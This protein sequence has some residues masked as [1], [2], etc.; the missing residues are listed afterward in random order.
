MTILKSNSAFAARGFVLFSETNS[1]SASKSITVSAN[2]IE[3]SDSIEGP[4][5]SSGVR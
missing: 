1:R 2:Y 5:P 4:T 3:R